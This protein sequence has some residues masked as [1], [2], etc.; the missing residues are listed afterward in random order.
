[1]PCIHEFGILDDLVKQKNYIHYE[2]DQYNCISVNDNVIQG[3]DKYLSVMKTYF[4]SISRSECGLA[5][6]GITIIS[7]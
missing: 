4:H 5:Y 6:S 7:A 2:P 3:L 1:M